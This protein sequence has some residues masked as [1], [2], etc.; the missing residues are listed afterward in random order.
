MR[1]NMKFQLR[2]MYQ[3]E[4]VLVG[5]MLRDKNTFER[6]RITNRML[7]EMVAKGYVEIRPDRVRVTPKGLYHITE[8]GVKKKTQKEYY[9]EKKAA[10]FVVRQIWVHQDDL[11]R[12][13]EVMKE[14]RR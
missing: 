5:M 8:Q 13:D 3:N 4:C 10:G 6:Y 7:L 14:F 12:F 1:H 2:R 9:D 11:D